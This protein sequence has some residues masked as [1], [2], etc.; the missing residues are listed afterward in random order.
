MSGT[1]FKYT[2]GRIDARFSHAAEFDYIN[3]R[4]KMH[5]A[6]VNTMDCD[7][8]FR[9]GNSVNHADP[10]LKFTVYMSSVFCP[11]KDFIRFLEAIA[12]QVQECS[13][14]WDPEGPSAKME[15]SRRFPYESGF[16]TVSWHGPKGWRNQ[17]FSHRMMLSTRQTVSMFYTAFRRFVESPD[18]EPTRYEQMTTGEAFALMLAD[19][20][21]EKLAE[22]LAEMNKDSAEK[23]LIVMR[24][25]LAQH[26]ITG[27]H[28][29]RSLGYYL[30]EASKFK[31]DLQAE[32]SNGVHKDWNE[33]DKL[34][35]ITDIFEQV[36]P[37]SFS[38]C[39]SG[40]NLRTLRSPLI[41]AY[42]S[43][44]E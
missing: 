31:D 34:Q 20:T 7:D 30:Q 21:L 14:E 6:V 37:Y 2:P 3:L 18:Y 40:T 27:R 10:S 35:R 5:G 19:S 12:I 28:L 22:T 4:I 8:K 42:L 43:G 13:F 23:L 16:L 11:F 1:F 25:D 29:R 24:D 15:W 44:A 26:A 38:G 17:Q 39:W 36:Y 9:V 41:E 32:I 33:F